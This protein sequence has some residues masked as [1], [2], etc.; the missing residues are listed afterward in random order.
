VRT[1]YSVHLQ[2]VVSDTHRTV[3]NASEQD[4][5]HETDQPARRNTNNHAALHIR[6]C[7]VEPPGKSGAAEA[8]AAAHEAVQEAQRRVADRVEQPAHWL[9]ADD[10]AGAAT[11]VGDEAELGSCD[12][13]LPPF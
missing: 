10:H 6:E 7:A 4:S 1:G 12:E 5:A 13:A 9:A 11:A 3:I 8:V 2:E